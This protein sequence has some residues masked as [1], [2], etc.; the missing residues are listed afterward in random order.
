MKLEIVGAVARR[1]RE[2][3]TAAGLAVLCT[4]LGVPAGLPEAVAQAV[5]A[6]AGLLAGVLPESRPAP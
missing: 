6:V 3:S 4:L 2:P 1:L 5:T